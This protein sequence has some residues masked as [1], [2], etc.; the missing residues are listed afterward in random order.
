MLDQ[1]WSFTSQDEYLDWYAEL[2]EYDRQQALVLMRLMAYEVLER[3]VG[4]FRDQA[5]ELLDTVP[6]MMD[7]DEE[8]RPRTFCVMWDCNGLEAIG[9]VAD[10]AIK[11]L[12]GVG[13]QACAPRRFQY[14]TLATASPIQ[15][16]TVL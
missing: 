10:P 15:H 7:D 8:S 3:R 11:N 12:G 14:P 5:C 16:T 4:E 13:Q 1:I 9:E 2:D 6:T